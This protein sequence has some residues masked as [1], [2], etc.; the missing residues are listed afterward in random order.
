MKPSKQRD[1]ISEYEKWGVQPPTVDIHYTQ[2]QIDKEFAKQQRLGHLWR[3]P[4][5]GAPIECTSC[6]FMH[7]S[8]VPTDVLLKG[9]DENGLPILEKINI[10]VDKT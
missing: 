7:R 8:M 1:N 4:G 3:Q 9:T 2:E 6:P 10:I 5:V